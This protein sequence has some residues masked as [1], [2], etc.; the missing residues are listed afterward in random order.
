[1]ADTIEFDESAAEWLERTYLT[2]DV[3]DQRM[4]VLE[5]VDLQ[6]GERVLD[7][8]VGPGLLALDMASLVG[9][10]GR[11]RGVDLSDAML[12]MSK[13]RCAELDQC[14][15]RKADAT[16]LPFEDGEFDAV[17]STQVYEYVAD[18]PAALAEARRV[19]APG[20]RLVIL[21]TAWDSAV[22][23]TSDPQ[24]HDRVMKVWDEHLVHPNLPARLAPLLR[25]AGFGHVRSSSFAMYT[26][27]YQPHSYAAGII[28]VIAGF[29]GGRSGVSDDEA[30]AWH[31]D[32]V[33]LGERGEFFFSVNRYLFSAIR[34]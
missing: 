22:L 18:M 3:V 16:D 25:D 12:A 17:V 14:A 27:S 2:P 8:G 32:L 30:R 4:R 34:E 10:G 29:V 26:P 1:M 28:G 20:G 24:R 15:F 7:I 6:P 13:R 33:A 21:D 11:L 31:A 23:N 5:H 19:L 9:P